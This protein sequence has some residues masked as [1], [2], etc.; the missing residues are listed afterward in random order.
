MDDMDD[1]FVL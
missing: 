1:R